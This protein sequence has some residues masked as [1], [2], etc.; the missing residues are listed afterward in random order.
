[1]AELSPDQFAALFTREGL[2]PF[3]PRPGD[4]GLAP[5][6]EV[7][8]PDAALVFVLAIDDFNDWATRHGMLAE[9][10]YKCGTEHEVIALRF[11]SEAWQRYFT[12]EELVARGNR[13]VETYADKVEVIMVMGQMANGPGYVASAPLHRREDGTVE[14]LGSWQVKTVEGR[15][16]SQIMESF[17]KGYHAAK[18]EAHHG[19]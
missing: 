7:L 10:G 15:D 17:W 4:P 2:R 14:R 3:Q 11:G 16:R 12:P 19:C 5:V 18:R 6:L 13:L 9:L 1:M 8:T